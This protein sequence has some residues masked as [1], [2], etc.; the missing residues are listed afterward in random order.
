MATSWLHWIGQ[1]YY[2]AE[3]FIDE[4]QRIG[5]TRRVSLQVLKGMS[6]GDIVSCV[7]KPKNIKGG[8]VFLEFPIT[9]LSGLTGGAIDWIR[10]SG[11]KIIK[12]SDG[13]DFVD[14]G[15]GEYE[16]G[17]AYSVRLSLPELAR[18]LE[19]MKQKG[20]DIGKLMVGCSAD[21]VRVVSEPRPVL[22]A[23]PFRQGFRS[24]NRRGFWRTVRSR[25]LDS[26]RFRVIARGQFYMDAVLSDTDKGKAQEI[27][28]Y[29]QKS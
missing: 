12:V 15:C 19:F 8:A 27:K 2:T 29:R 13:G 28:N 5:I 14:R 23:L 7:Q 20:E 3:T 1:Q 18:M 16:T 10:E 4:A 6:W 21:R 9:S 26:P 22:N 25:C 11:T 17:A 24:W